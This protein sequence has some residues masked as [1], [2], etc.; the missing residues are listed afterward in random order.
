[1]QETSFREILELVI[2]KLKGKYW[3]YISANE[4]VRYL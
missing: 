1:M 2:C 3:S 4:N